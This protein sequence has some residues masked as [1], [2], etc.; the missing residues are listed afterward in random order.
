[1]DRLIETGTAG[2]ARISPNGNWVAY[3][4]TAADWKADVFVSQI[5]LA[6]TA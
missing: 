2:G 6:D 1:M 3:S 5:W 4:V